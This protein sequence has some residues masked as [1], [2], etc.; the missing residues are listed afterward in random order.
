VR[1]LLVGT[2]CGGGLDLLPDAAAGNPGKHS[3]KLGIPGLQYGRPL[4]FNARVCEMVVEEWS[5]CY[6]RIFMRV[7]RGGVRAGRNVGRS[8][9]RASLVWSAAAELPLL[10]VSWYA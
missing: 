3:L 7:A 8:R 5:R 10:K 2:G 6:Q 1:T 9:R 4:A